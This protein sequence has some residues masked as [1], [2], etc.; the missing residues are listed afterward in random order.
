M[1]YENAKILSPT[2]KY[3]PKTKHEYKSLSNIYFG[4]NVFTHFF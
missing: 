1:P 2:L 4:M 3:I